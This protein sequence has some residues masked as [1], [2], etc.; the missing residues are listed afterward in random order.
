VDTPG[1]VTALIA[2]DFGGSTRG[3]LAVGWHQGTAGY[4]GGVKFYYLDAGTL[5]PFGVDPSAGSLTNWV[6]ALNANDFNYGTNPAASAPYLVDLAVGVKVSA[7]TGAV[8]VF[9]R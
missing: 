7:L 9:V 1:I 6:P 4:A 3:D 5:P 2:A 8:V